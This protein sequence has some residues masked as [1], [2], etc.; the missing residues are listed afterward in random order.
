M[1]NVLEYVEQAAAEHPHNVFIA[2]ENHELTGEALL[3]QAR[4]IGT[5]LIQKGSQKQVSR[6]SGF[7]QK[8][9]AIYMDKSPACA[10]AMLGV[11]YSGNFY[12][13]LDTAQPADRILLIL[14]TLKPAAILTDSA[15]FADAGGLISPSASPEEETEP[16]IFCLEEA[17]TQEEVP[18]LLS[19]IRRQT[20]DTD[21]LYVLYTSGSTGVP[22]G[23]V[24]SHRA[25]IAYTHWVI[26]TFHIDETVIYG[27]QTPF[28]F[29]MS[30]TD[31]YSTLFTGARLQIIPKKYFSFPTMLIDYLNQYKINTLYWVPSALGIVSSWDTFAYKMPGFLKNIMFAGEVMPVKCLNYWRS[32]LPDAVFSNLF[33]PTETTDICTWYTVNREFANDES[34]PIGHACGNCDSFVVSEDGTK[35]EPSDTESI[36]ELYVRGSFLS[37]GYYQNPEKTTEVFVQNPLQKDYPETVYKTGD[38]VRYNSFGELLYIG[39]RDLQIKH[40][41]YRIE[42]GEI[43]TACNGLETVETS[44]CIYDEKTDQIIIF[45][46]GKG[47][48]EEIGSLLQKKLPHYMCPQKIEKLRQMP[49]NANGKTDRKA[50]KKMIGNITK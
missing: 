24:I 35:I 6:S 4:R 36:G 12:V 18:S 26:E 21:L 39:R 9:I 42:P 7:F 11:V 30:V 29:S 28:Y 50:L 25:V 40:M 16:F 1:K 47:S 5:W 19:Q 45:Y 3:S 49:H 43:E 37:C 38:L 48:P 34:L 17:L 22:K 46:Q 2:D 20:T 33:G 10:A 13:I 31:L 27:S 15:H 44:V 41:G 32:Y 23:A 14:N 8:P